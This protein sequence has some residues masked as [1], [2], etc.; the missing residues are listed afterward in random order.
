MNASFD[1]VVV[2]LYQ[3]RGVANI[4]GVV[5][6]MKNMGARYLR[7]VAPAAFDPADVTGIAHRSEDIL[8]SM[9][10]YAALDAALADA[11]YVV[12]TTARHRGDRPVRDDV[13]ALAADLV[14]RAAVGRVALLFGPEDNG[15]DNPALD[16]CHIVVRLPV[17]PAYPS[18]NLAQA[19]LLLMYELRMATMHTAAAAMSVSAPADSQ[20]LE[21][22][23]AATEQAL[24]SVEFF[25]SANEEVIMRR[26]RTLV[27]RVEP[28]RREAALLTAIA[29]EVEAFARRIG[30]FRREVP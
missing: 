2:V 8:A 5:R 21:T 13:R 9:Q 18:L 6:A 4:G 14:R 30:A 15:L 20:T 10:I 19:A 28:D 17:D 16:R 25:K 26:L 24:R 12:G 23:F 29:R 1:N 3:P 7:L 27:Y 22:L 11:S